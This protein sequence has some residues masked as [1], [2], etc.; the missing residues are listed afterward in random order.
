M[1][2]AVSTGDIVHMA[3]LY[4]DG[5]PPDLFHQSRRSSTSRQQR[6]RAAPA[7]VVVDAAAVVEVEVMRA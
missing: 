3:H 1:K 6:D 5:L 4:V 7:A 2:I